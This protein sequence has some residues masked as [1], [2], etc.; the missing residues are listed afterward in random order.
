MDFPRTAGFSPEQLESIDPDLNLLGLLAYSTLR[1]HAQRPVQE[2][3]SKP[4]SSVQK[5]V[6]TDGDI[7]G[8]SNAS[9]GSN[10]PSRSWNTRAEPMP[11][12]IIGMS[13]RSP[14]GAD[15][16]SKFWDLIADGKAAWSEIPR[17]KFNTAAYYY[18]NHLRADAV[19][20]IC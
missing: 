16:I 17:D 6:E 10:V 19:R 3:R 12:A 7:F 4:R 15:S 2:I 5:P 13:C 18:P 20:K 14:G 1:E 9:H 11:V 8:S